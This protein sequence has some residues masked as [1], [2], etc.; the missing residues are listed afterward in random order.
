[1][2]ERILIIEEQK[3]VAELLKDYLEMNDYSVDIAPG[4]ESGLRMALGESYAMVLLEI[5][6]EQMDGYEICKRIKEEKMIPVMFL[7]ERTN[8]SDVI[9]ALNI[10]AD[11]Y[12]R[13]PFSPG[14]M[15]ARVKGHLAK[16]DKFLRCA[17][18]KNEILKVGDLHL[19]KTARQIWRGSEEINLCTKEFDLLTF[20]MENV[21]HVF[22]KEELFEKI[23]HAQG[24][25]D[26]ATVTVHIKKLRDKLK[27]DAEH[28][29]YIETVW[30][31]GYRLRGDGDEGKDFIRG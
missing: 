24:I 12:M 3:E 11:D 6:F 28:P 7:S 29:R 18:Q 27:D 16:Y 15:V 5:N 30:G 9:R 31:A 19:D 22:S 25:G 1:M 21:N 23:W 17:E 13:K 8:E 26:I 4:A 14:E 2:N 10:G 20:L